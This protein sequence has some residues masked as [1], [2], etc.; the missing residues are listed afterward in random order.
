MWDLYRKNCQLLIEMGK[1]V[2]E[3]KSAMEL[4]EKIEATLQ[5][6]TPAPPGDAKVQEINKL[7][8][9]GIILQ[10][11]TREVAK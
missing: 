4:K 8:N 10:L 2:S 5:S 9:G 11:E 6:V 1:E 3:G 7:R